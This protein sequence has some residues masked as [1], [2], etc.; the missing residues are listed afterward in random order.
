[1]IL[2]PYFFSNMGMTV[3]SM[4]A[5]WL[6]APPMTSSLGWLPTMAGTPSVDMAAAPAVV[7]NCRRVTGAVIASSSRS[8]LRKGVE[9]LGASGQDLMLRLR[10]QLRPIRDQLGRAGEEAVG[11]RIVR[12]PEDLVRPDVV[13]EHG[14]TALDGLERDPAVAPEQ[15]ARVH[16]QVG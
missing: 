4:N 9:A 16:A 10:R 3:G 6:A 15:L 12:R 5:L 14:E 1:M 13:R 8:K 11:M 2:Q 7:R